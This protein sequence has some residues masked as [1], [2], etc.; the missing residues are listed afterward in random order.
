MI[1]RRISS[2]PIRS[3]RELVILWN[4][5]AGGFADRLDIS[6]CEIAFGIDIDDV[7]DDGDIDVAVACGRVPRATTSSACCGTWGTEQFES[8]DYPTGGAR[9]MD[10]V[11]VDLDLD[12]DSDLAIGNEDSGDVSVLLNDGVGGYGAPSS[13]PACGSED[14]NS[15]VAGDLGWRHGSGSR[16]R[17]W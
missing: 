11:F 7:D 15:I 13:H 16:R 3:S 5:G 8:T 4:D 12:G 14:L 1:R 17:V 10:T 9:A 2:S 6:V